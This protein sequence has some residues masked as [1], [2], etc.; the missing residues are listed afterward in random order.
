MA[1]DTEDSLELIV[2]AD[3]QK[4]NKE[5][6]KLVMQLD[7]VIAKLRNAKSQKNKS[8][9]PG[10]EEARKNIIETSRQIARLNKLKATKAPES[11][12]WKK[13]GA[14][15]SDAGTRLQQYKATA[16]GLISSVGTAKP[17]AA[18]GIKIESAAELA[19]AQKTVARLENA[20]KRN[21]E[22][23]LKYQLTGNTRRFN[24]ESDKLRANTELLHQYE[25]AVRNASG[26]WSHM[27]DAGNIRIQ[28][29][30]ELEAA[31]KAAKKLE[32]SIENDTAAM[33][34]FAVANDAP[35]VER[36]KAKIDGSREAL[37]RYKAALSGAGGLAQQR[38]NTKALEKL[39]ANI[40]RLQSRINNSKSGSA[41][42]VSNTA[43]VRRLKLE[44]LDAQIQ[45][46]RLKTA[47]GQIG[48]K[49]STAERMR[50][51]AKNIGLSLINM[52]KLNAESRKTSKALIN[53]SRALSLMAFR[54][55]VRTIMR[56]TKEGIQN[57][58]KYSKE[59]DNAFNG[60]MSR[61]MSKVT[62]LK[63]AFATAI[64]PV[65]QMI[66]P[67]VV[68][69]INYIISGINAISLA[70]AA[71]FGQDTFYKALPVSED[72]A[73]SLDTA[74][75]NAKKLKRQLLGIDELTILEPN[76]TG[77]PGRADPS[78]MFTIE[79][80]ASPESQATLARLKQKLE[81]MLPLV[82]AIGAAL[83]VWRLTP[84]LL[85][86]L[87]TA[88][89]LAELFGTSTGKVLGWAAFFAVMV[90]RFADLYANSE[91]FRTGLERIGEIFGGLKTAAGDVLDG[92]GTVLKDIGTAAL[93]MLPE[94]WRDAILDFF[95]KMKDWLDQLDLDWKDLALTIAGIAL[96]FVPGGKLLGVALL[97]FEALTVG[98]RAFGNVSD[99]EWES[100]KLKAEQV[101]NRV[102]MVA[103]AVYTNLKQKCETTFNGIK[104]FLSG[105]FTGDWERIWSGLGDYI[106]VCL[107]AASAFCKW[108][109]GV[110]L[111]GVVKT[112]FD[113]YVKPW[114]SVDRWRQL[115]LDVVSG[116]KS[117][118]KNLGN[119]IMEVIR[120]KLPDWLLN[121]LD[122]GSMNVSFSGGGSGAAGRYATV[123][124][125]AS[126]G[127]PTTGQL[128][129]A[130]EAGPEL[131]GRMGGRTAVANND[132]IVASIA[133]GV[134]S[135]NDGV[136]N[137]LY[138]VCN[139]VISAIDEKDMN[140]YLDTRKVTDETTRTQNRR[141]RM[142][143]KNMSN[144]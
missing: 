81:K 84:A 19:D 139:R 60:S 78:E 63:N 37:E 107:G 64:A 117:G 34:R 43:T 138:A 28:T 127:F 9:L 119:T 61:M 46:N 132:Q 90:G 77:T 68:K 70:L 6:E 45:A 135:A 103:E 128:F 123:S 33:K 80:V 40:E 102:K 99:E 11:E 3:S 96:L 144:A 52:A 94:K 75:E 69:I 141:N 101:W 130:R 120:S 113:E 12:D 50:L 30:E 115:G 100:F 36:M 134:S 137:A 2:E 48:V 112:W 35:G 31:E 93:N 98:I 125:Y 65:V 111:I 32:R 14:A 10:L 57:L 54:Y 71:L 24:A 129:V 88:T 140:A 82:K 26:A 109:F 87:S 62:E 91:K 72:Y 56:L 122:K 89:R 86:G 29:V 58:A 83:A 95:A 114:F 7:E 18:A 1:V 76:N 59:V 66:E 97:A 143:N 17:A 124:A 27:D 121:L 44:L 13:V 110:D 4:A 79:S 38:D 42:F 15:I 21:R 47:L 104:D 25:E 116:L 39:Y 23:Q 53:V 118:L 92:I 49:E 108:I 55:T 131:V 136:I 5:L 51:M 20:I 74:A 8:L 41:S 126:G 67:Y 133:A 22:N 105:V 16:E 142:Y 85:N 106:S 73:E